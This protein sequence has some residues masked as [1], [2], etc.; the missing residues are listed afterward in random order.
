MRSA[1]LVAVWLCGLAAGFFALLS[2]AAKY[3]TC[4]SH[5]SGLACRASGSG[6]GFAIVVAVILVVAVATATTYGRDTRRVLVI[7]LVAIAALA[8]CLIAARSLLGTA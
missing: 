8:G 6:L 2:G 4:S 3:T 5:A 1:T 7:G